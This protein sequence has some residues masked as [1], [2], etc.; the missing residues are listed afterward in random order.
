LRDTRVLDLGC[1]RGGGL[2]FLCERFD[3]K[4]ALGVDISPRQI[5][6]AEE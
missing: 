6:F 5:A 2:T 4:Q 3:A 1:G